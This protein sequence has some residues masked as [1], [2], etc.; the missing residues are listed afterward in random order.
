MASSHFVACSYFALLGNAHAHELIDARRQ[1]ITHVTRKHFDFDNF[2]ALSVRY[3]QGSILDFTGLFTEDSSQEFLFRRQFRLALWRDFT[4]KNILR[5]Y[6]RA[7][8]DDAALVQ[9][10]QTLFTDIGYIASNLF[11]AKLSVARIDLILLDVYR[12]KVVFA[13]DAFADENGVLVVATFPTHE[14]DENVLPESK[15]PV[16]C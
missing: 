15:L 5:P 10:A 12:G 2:A 1:F 6:F 16:F 13:D 4:D 9:V 3:A 14:G 7:D 11:G 8:I